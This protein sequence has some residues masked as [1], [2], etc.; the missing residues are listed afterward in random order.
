M[1][2]LLPKSYTEVE[3]WIC[4]VNC[5]PFHLDLYSSIGLGVAVLA[6]L[7]CLCCACKRCC[8]SADESSMREEPLDSP[9]RPSLEPK[10]DLPSNSDQQPPPVLEQP[11]SAADHAQHRLEQITV[12][13]A[14]GSPSLA[15]VVVRP[16]A[17]VI[18]GAGP[19]VLPE[20]L[21]DPSCCVDPSP[22]QSPGSL[23]SDPGSSLAPAGMVGLSGGEALGGFPGWERKWDPLKMRPDYVDHNTR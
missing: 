4:D 6:L 17:I 1:A 15:P 12:E 19:T 22:P 21:S 3:D 7:C 10:T 18:H 11:S 5:L 16:A 2:D 9:Q 8:C 20:S 23:V 14:A 13:L